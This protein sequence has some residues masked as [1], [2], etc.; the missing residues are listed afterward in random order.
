[1]YSNSSEDEHSTETWHKREFNRRLDDHKS[2]TF[3]RIRIN[4]I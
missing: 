2:K 1:M 4:L 3:R